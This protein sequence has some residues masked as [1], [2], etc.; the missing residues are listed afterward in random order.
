MLNSTLTFKETTIEFKQ[1]SSIPLETI[2]FPNGVK[3]GK[4]EKLIFDVYKNGEEL[5]NYTLTVTNEGTET[6]EYR[7]YSQLE[8]SDTQLVYGFYDSQ[9]FPFNAMVNLFSSLTT[10]EQRK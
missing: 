1:R 4:R 3:S 6:A 8:D 7:L 9:N 5:E 10:Y 2:T